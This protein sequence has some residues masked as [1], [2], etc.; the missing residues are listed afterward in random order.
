LL[1]NCSLER[2]EQLVEKIRSDVHALRFSSCGRIFAVSA[3]LGIARIRPGCDK[4]NQA[5]GDADLACHIAKENGGN[6]IHVYQSD[7]AELVR[8]QEEMQWVSRISD[9]IKLDQLVLYCQPIVPLSARGDAGFHVEVLVRMLDEGGTIINPDRFLPAAERYH[10]VAGLDSWV[11]SHSLDWYAGYAASRKTS[12]LDTLSINL[13]GASIGDPKVLEHIKREIS[14]HAVP[15]EVLCFEITETA[16]ISN[17]SA[18]TAFIHELRLLGCRFALDDF[19]S[20]LSSFAYLKNMPVDYLKI[21]GTFV[22]DMDTNEVNF[23]MVSAIQ[24]LGNVIGISTV[25]EYVCNE[26]ILRKLGEL[27]VDYA[28]GFVI[29]KPFALADLGADPELSK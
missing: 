26:E 10:L 7:D 16:A 2:A 12:G 29:A 21:D 15:P 19:G 11:I 13:S 17:L 24:Q 23:A 6:R 8:R 14:S 18:A 1:K 28:Q 9:A 4:V 27:G 20:G 25:A 3:S 22:R 5:M